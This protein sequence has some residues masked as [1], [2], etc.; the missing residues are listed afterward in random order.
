MKTPK[1]IAIEMLRFDSDC[2]F[3]YYYERDHEDYD[4]AS[5]AK[6]REIGKQIRKI[7]LRFLK[8]LDKAKGK[9]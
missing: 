7:E 2:L 6:Q 3:D 4:K 1:Q 8:M 5:E 9:K